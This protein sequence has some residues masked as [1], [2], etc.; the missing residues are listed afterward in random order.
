MSVRPLTWALTTSTHHEG[1]GSLNRMSPKRQNPGGKR[2]QPPLW[3]LWAHDNKWGQTAHGHF[4]ELNSSLDFGTWTIWR[5]LLREILQTKSSLPHSP[6]KWCPSLL[7]T[8]SWLSLAGFSCHII[9]GR[10]LALAATM[11]L[12]SHC[13]SC[14]NTHN[15]SCVCEREWET[16]K[17]AWNTKPVMFHLLH[18]QHE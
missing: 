18:C 2:P 9:S 4:Y 5:T 7:I 12:S 16:S 15:G 11:G 8:R 1:E 3:L 13:F 14:L 10:H 6:S 17:H